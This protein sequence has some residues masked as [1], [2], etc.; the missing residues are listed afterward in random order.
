M[1]PDDPDN[2]SAKMSE[3][4]RCLH[5]VGLRVLREAT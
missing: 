5:T 2:R 3:A 4:G 1:P